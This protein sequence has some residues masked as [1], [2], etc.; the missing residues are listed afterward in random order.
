MMLRFRFGWPLPAVAHACLACE[1]RRA[2]FRTLGVA[3]WDRYH[4]LCVRCYRRALDR[5]PVPC[6]AEISALD[7]PSSTRPAAV[8]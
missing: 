2:M 1:C 8:A 6:G 4:A 5:A 7:E 3:K